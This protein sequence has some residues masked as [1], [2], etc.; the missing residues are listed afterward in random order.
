MAMTLTDG[1]PRLRRKARSL[2]DTDESFTPD[3]LQRKGG[4][5]RRVWDWHLHFP[6]GEA[7]VRYSS[8]EATPIHALPVTGL[9]EEQDES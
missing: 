5:A 3:R 7:T 1:I 8:E 4:S 6:P 9:R 2:R